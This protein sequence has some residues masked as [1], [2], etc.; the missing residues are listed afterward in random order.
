MSE[1]RNQYR[2]TAVQKELIDAAQSICDE[3]DRST[4]YMLQYC[5]D[6]SG[7]DYDAVVD[8]IVSK[9]QTHE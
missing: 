8:Y 7:A 5:S 4:E 9:D 6:M 2:L 1:R 3:E